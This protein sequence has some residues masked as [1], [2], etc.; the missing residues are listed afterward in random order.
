[1][2]PAIPIQ[3]AVLICED[4]PSSFFLCALLFHGGQMGDDILMMG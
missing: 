1:M 2:E 3:D 4:L